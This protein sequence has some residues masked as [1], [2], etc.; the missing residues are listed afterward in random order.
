MNRTSIYYRFSLIVT[1]CFFAAS[2]AFAQQVFTVTGVIFKKNT[3]I[4]IAQ[5]T[6]T[7]ITRKITAEADELG[8]FHILAAMGDTLLFTKSEYM[9]QTALV[10]TRIDLS[11]YMQPVIQLNEVT[12]KDV[13]KQ[14]ELNNV[15]DEYKR[16]GQYSTLSPSVGS[17]LSSPLN[18]LYELFGKGPAQARRFKE[19][20]D[21][22]MERIAI[23]KRYNS[24]LVQQVTNIPDSEIED[25]MASFNPSYEDIKV[26]SDYDIIKYI[27]KSYEYFQSHKGSLK[28]PKLY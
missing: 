24:K 17:V 11:I 10:Q 8:G 22:E 19:Y 9:A 7:N 1:V 18:G 3:P 15:L 4:T 2:G 23:S 16:K 21:Q 12:I 5:A 27:K 13:S 14:Q 6:V 28:A 25:F 20:T 26:W